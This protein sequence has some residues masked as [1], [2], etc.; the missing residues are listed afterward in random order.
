VFSSERDNKPPVVTLLTFDGGQS[1]TYTEAY[2]L[3]AAAGMVATVYVI[4]DRVGTAGYMT[5]AQL[6]ELHAAGWDIA[7]HTSDHTELGTLATAA[8]VAAKVTDCADYLVAAGMPEASLHVAYPGG[9]HEAE[10]L[11]GMALAGALT[12]RTRED[13]YVGYSRTNPCELP[14][15]LA[16]NDPATSW[17]VAAVEAT[18]WTGQV[19]IFTLHGLVVAPS[20]PEEWQITSFAGLVQYLLNIGAETIT[21]SEWYARSI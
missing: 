6:Q 12:G 7:N 14:T 8:E 1:S 19:A 2:P 21:I 9:D 16:V 15:K 3:L 13:G 11:A 17:A 20:I 10:T 5:L 4:S 18:R